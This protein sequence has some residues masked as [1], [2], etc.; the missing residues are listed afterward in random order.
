MKRATEGKSLEVEGG[1]VRGL[2]EGTVASADIKDRKVSEM[3]WDRNIQRAGDLRE[4]PKTECCGEFSSYVD[5]RDEFIFTCT[6]ARYVERVLQVSRR[7]SKCQK[8]V[9]EA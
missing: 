6:D 8:S 5:R 3:A 7:N 2:S 4:C 9:L 1:D